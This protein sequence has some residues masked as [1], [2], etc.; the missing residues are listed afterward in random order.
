MNHSLCFGDRSWQSYSH[1]MVQV[2]QLET[3]L[4]GHAY[5]FSVKPSQRP[6]KFTVTLVKS[7]STF[8]FM[9]QPKTIQRKKVL[10]RNIDHLLRAQETLISM[11]GR[12]CGCNCFRSCSSPKVFIHSPPSCKDLV[13][14]PLR[15]SFLQTA[16]NE[17]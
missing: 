9:G 6:G 3:C 8:H 16:L 2:I 13:S 10:A 15:N 12:P 14:L 5:R 11:T 1:S 17:V 4:R 7:C